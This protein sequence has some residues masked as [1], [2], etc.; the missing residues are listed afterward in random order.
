MDGTLQVVGLFPAPQAGLGPRDGGRKT[1]FSLK[2]MM[3]RATCE[4]HSLARRKEDSRY[5]WVFKLWTPGLTPFSYSPQNWEE[6]EAGSAGSGST[7]VARLASSVAGRL[8]QPTGSQ[9]WTGL[10]GTLDL[11]G[12]CQRSC[13]SSHGPCSGCI[14]VS[15]SMPWGR[16]ERV[17]D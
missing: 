8:P 17:G 16:G 2:G 3:H 1:K 12:V 14:L 6:D 11:S 9:G 7:A 5:G 13:E 10:D 15:Q 4:K